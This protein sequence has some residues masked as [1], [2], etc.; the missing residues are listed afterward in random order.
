MIGAKA[1]VEFLINAPFDKLLTLFAKASIGI[2]TMVDEHFGINIVELMVSFLLNLLRLSLMFQ[3]AAGIIPVVH[4]SAG[5]LLDIVVPYKDEPV[6]FHAAT[7][8]EFAVRFNEILE[9]SPENQEILRANARA[10]VL[11][12]FT[13]DK[14]IDGFLVAISKHV[15]F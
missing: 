8:Q 4:P 5:P 1:N 10:S 6:G 12:R 11:D 7:S 14:F 2:S 9:M 13:E 3:K 15:Q